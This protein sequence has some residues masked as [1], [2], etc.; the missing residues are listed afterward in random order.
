VFFVQQITPTGTTIRGIY[1]KAAG[2]TK[3]QCGFT[4]NSPGLRNMQ[5]DKELRPMPSLFRLLST[6]AIVAVVSACGGKPVPETGDRDTTDGGLLSD[7]S[8]TLS[9]IPG[10][11]LFGGGS[12]GSGGLVAV[13]KHLWKASL[14]TLAFLPLSSTDPF[15]GVIATD[16]ASSPDAP[17]ERFKVAAYVQSP[18][19]TTTALKVAVFRE[20]RDTS[21]AWVTAAV[22][23]VTARRLEDAILVRAR[24][25]KLA[26]REQG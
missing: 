18:Q 17:N 16:W 5:S 22:S 14:D 4:P 1:H 24:Q 21:G 10:F 6:A 3:A 13:N 8:T 20:I 23:G 26:E 2:I 15:T 7:G 12:G 19:L 25:L 9:D 11:D